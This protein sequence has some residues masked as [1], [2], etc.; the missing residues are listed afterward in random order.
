LTGGDMNIE[1]QLSKVK[2]LLS[3][4]RILVVED[5]DNA[6][7]TYCGVLQKE[8]YLVDGAGNLEEAL[9]RIESRTY[10]V[11]VVDIMLAGEHDKNNRDGLIVLNKI[12]DARYEIR[13]GNA[14]S[15]TGTR[16][17]ALTGQDDPQ[18]A[19][20]L[21]I[22]YGVNDYIDKDKYIF[23]FADE[24][25]NRVKS[26]VKEGKINLYAKER[27]ISFLAG[28]GN[29]ASWVDLT[30]RMFKVKGGYTGLERFFSALC[31]P[32]APLVPRKD[33]QDPTIV[34]K[35]MSIVIGEFWSKAL[36]LPIML[37]AGK[38]DVIDELIQSKKIPE[39]EPDN[40]LATHSGQGLTGQIFE[41]KNI[42][43]AGF[44]PQAG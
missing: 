25:I 22:Q 36:A 24:L 34:N 38:V 10:H 20:E 1:E 5:I 39:L 2:G 43:R 40:L 14:T 8:G 13:S 31:D 29:D 4:S 30:L 41:L 44:K 11:A 15:F 42:S 19:A 7:S 18:L 35:E 26:Q 23:S 3:K 6:R 21:V 33:A 28:T 17:I 9:N 16:S 12:K 37:V 27:V 32:I